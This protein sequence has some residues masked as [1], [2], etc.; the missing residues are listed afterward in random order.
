M[1]YRNGREAK[2]GDLVVGRCYN[3]KGLVAG[4]L[5]S[6]TPGMDSCSAKVAW[7]T[8]KILPTLDGAHFGIGVL[9]GTAQHFSGGQL[10][11]TQCRDDY[12]ECKNLLHV[13]DLA[14]NAAVLAEIQ[15]MPDPR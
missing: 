6:I 3:T 8:T 9:H 11:I 2:V 10:A 15:A 7:Q 12:T 1:H 5:V 13:D 4:T 14:S